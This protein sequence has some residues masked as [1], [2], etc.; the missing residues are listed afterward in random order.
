MHP[1]ALEKISYKI[2]PFKQYKNPSQKRSKGYHV[3]AILVG[4][5]YHAKYCYDG[6]R[7]Y[8]YF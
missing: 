5:T 4:T 3:F 7:F 1:L 2:F 8:G 6:E